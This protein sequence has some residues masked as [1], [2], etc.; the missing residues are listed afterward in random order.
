MYLVI[1]IIPVAITIPLINVTLQFCYRLCHFTE[2]KLRLKIQSHQIF[3][4]L[5]SVMKLTQHQTCNATFE[6]EGS[7]AVKV[8]KTNGSL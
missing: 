4:I 7:D 1:R 5:F 2:L 6:R 3:G 8:K